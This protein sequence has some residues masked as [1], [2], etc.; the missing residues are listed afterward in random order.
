MIKNPATYEIMT[1]EAVGAGETKL[2]F[3]KHSGR[4]ALM[5]RLT[6]LGITLDDSHFQ[7]VFTRLKS[8]ADNKMV[9]DDRD[10]VATVSESGQRL[11][12][13]TA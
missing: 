2:V 7:E 8:L 6:K 10:I 1:P 11:P 5:H 12:Q 4:H 3:G 13:E 9:V